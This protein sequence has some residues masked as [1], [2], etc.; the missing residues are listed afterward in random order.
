MNIE[1]VVFDIAGTTIADEGNIN[2]FF[3]RAFL[4]QECMMWLELI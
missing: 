2:D 3:R 4:M 1:L